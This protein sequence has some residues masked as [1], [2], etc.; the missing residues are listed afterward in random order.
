MKKHSAKASPAAGRNI[1][2]LSLSLFLLFF[3]N[4]LVGKCNVAFHWALP[5]LGSVA[6]FLLLAAA[7]TT[8][9]W[10]ALHREAGENENTKPNAKEV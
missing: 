10:A 1:L 5:H 7:S 2:R 3:V 9:I 6:E 8:L 4:I